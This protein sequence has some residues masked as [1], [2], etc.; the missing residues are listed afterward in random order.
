MEK[1][2]SDF[3]IWVKEHKKQLIVAGISVAAIVSIIIGIKN[4]DTIIELWDSLEKTVKKIPRSSGTS[5]LEQRTEVISSPKI[6]QP[7]IY[8]LP[9]ESFSVRQHIRTLPIGKQ[10]S[11][12]KAAE[13][14]LLGISLLPTQTLVDN[15]TK[16][17]A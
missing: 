9:E 7:R 2:K 5:I 1:V 14:A 3:C 4:K 17:A 6:L 10:H 8:T 16:F 15:Y 11:N 13:A 12:E